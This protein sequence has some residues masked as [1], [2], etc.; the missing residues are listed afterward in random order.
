MAAIWELHCTRAF[1]PGRA[2]VDCCARIVAHRREGAGAFQA[3]M[4]RLANCHAARVPLKRRT[5][6]DVQGRVGERDPA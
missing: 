2:L 3:A 4:P 5:Q 1:A 6:R